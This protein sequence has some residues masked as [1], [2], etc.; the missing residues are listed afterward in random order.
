[1]NCPDAGVRD[2]QEGREGMT[3]GPGDGPAPLEGNW[4]EEEEMETKQTE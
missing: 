1:M 2:D 4:A 3:M